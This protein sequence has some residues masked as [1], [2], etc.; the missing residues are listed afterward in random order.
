MP[1]A[2]DF[3]HAPFDCLTE[4][5]RDWVRGTVELTRYPKDTVLLQPD[6]PAMHVYVLISGH[7]QHSEAGEVVAVY[8]PG[9]FFAARA[10][11]AGRTTSVLTTLDEVSTYRLPQATLKNLVASNSAFSAMLFADLS[12]RLSAVAEGN[13][14]REFLSLMMAKVRDAYIRKPFFVD[15]HTD[16][17]TLCRHMAERGL[18]NALVRD[19]ADD[20]SARVGM[21]TT[22]DLRDALLR[23]EPP[24]QQSV[25]SLARFDLITV[26][27]D[28]ELFEALLVMLRHR[29][30]RVLVR[31]GDEILGVLSQLD[32]MSFI[33]NHSHIIALQVEQASSMAELKAAAQ[34]VDGLIELLHKGGV[35]IDV[36]S[37][38][39]S[40]LNTQI[41]AKLWSFLAPPELQANSC[42]LVMGSEGRGEQI[43]KTDQDNALI[44]RDGFECAHLDQVAKA[45]NQALTDFGYPRCPG[46]IM[47]V[48]PA[49]RLPLS[50]FKTTITDWLMGPHPDG[51]MNL[52]IFM[53][54]RAVA[55]D[56]SLLEQA[57]A[58]LQQLFNGNDALLARFARAVDQF[59]DSSSWWDRLIALR[60]KEEQAFDLK[61]LGTF[62]IVHGIRSLALQ[63]G[64]DAQGTQER[65][66]QLV[67]AG[68]LETVMANDLR[69][70]LQFLMGLKLT[71][72][73]R[74]RQLGLEAH[75]LVKLSELGTL[76]RDLLKD[77]LAII[78]RFRQHLRT[79]FRLDNI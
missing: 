46:N 10:V 6:M 15:G 77:S 34:Q 4:V 36:I 68:R 13:R 44:L 22:T 52:A 25:R 51:P 54:A 71:G 72:N 24:A 26:S 76:E 5:E 62:P 79:H 17:V 48:N 47:V 61:K 55:G 30:H 38:L 74:Q 66:R 33:S 59:S 16:L 32:L 27:P 53:D 28:T 3:S 14:Q 65:M 35:K 70:A 11:M 23:P 8:G 45:F 40:E 57:K 64:I 2:F 67:L 39:V 60:G 20:G 63:Y 58:Y 18:T 43:L 42:L 69:D 31:E 37:A 49:W 56:A 21:F 9:D 7:V 73:L 29:V 75:H 78:R 12:R 41:F 19:T 1:S 50:D